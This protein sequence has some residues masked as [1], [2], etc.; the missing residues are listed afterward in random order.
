MGTPQL[1]PSGSL[2]TGL[3]SI[4]SETRTQVYRRYFQDAIVRFTRARNSAKPR[5]YY[6]GRI[7]L[8]LVCKEIYLESHPIYAASVK[9]ILK[10]TRISHIAAARQYHR[11]KLLQYLEIV[12][13]PRMALYVGNLP[14]LKTLK[15]SIPG[16]LRGWIFLRGALLDDVL[17]G[18]ILEGAIREAVCQE[19]QE[20]PLLFQIPLNARRV[21]G[22]P[23]PSRVRS[24]LQTLADD[25]TRSFRIIETMPFQFP[26]N[27][28]YFP[29]TT[30]PG[31]AGGP[32]LVSLL[33]LIFDGTLI[34]VTSISNMMLIRERHCASV[35]LTMSI[36]PSRS[37]RKEQSRHTEC[38]KTRRWE[39]SLRR[40]WKMLRLRTA[41]SQT[42]LQ[43]E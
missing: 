14:A 4:P 36:A 22:L 43:A 33:V 2:F 18:G 9:L 37:G 12:D 25:P 23:K 28:A 10:N 11:I 32:C 27:V 3:F 26:E 34:K 35:S 15:I 1:S 42:A 24:W 5:A 17:L 20:P 8:M 21:P 6:K 39:G 13:E 31:E 29:A 7:E 16:H 38:S 19:A 41:T 30:P 40:G